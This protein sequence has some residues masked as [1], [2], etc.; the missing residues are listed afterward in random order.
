ML[1][2]LRGYLIW[3]KFGVDL[4]QTQGKIGNFGALTLRIFLIWRNIF[5]VFC[6]CFV[7]CDTQTD[8]LRIICSEI[9]DVDL[10][11][12][13]LPQISIA[14]RHSPPRLN[15]APSSYPHCI[16]NLPSITHNAF[17]NS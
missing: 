13:C 5:I 1:F 6:F 11:L 16:I 15:H 4:I 12:M 9:T 7:F 10:H 17:F 3:R 2:S 14:N 8:A